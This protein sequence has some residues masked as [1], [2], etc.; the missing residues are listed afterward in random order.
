MSPDALSTV[1]EFTHFDGEYSAAGPLLLSSS[2]PEIIAMV[3]LG[4]RRLHPE[5][6]FYGPILT[7]GCD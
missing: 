2:L 1:G 4:N 7:S 6:P 5:S 3:C